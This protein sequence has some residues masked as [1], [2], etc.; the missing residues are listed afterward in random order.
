MLTHTHWYDNNSKAQ[1]LP[2]WGKTSFINNRVQWQLSTDLFVC[3]PFMH[4]IMPLRCQRTQEHPVFI[5][6]FLFCF[7][8]YY[9]SEFIFYVL[10]NVFSC[11]PFKLYFKVSFE[12][13]KE[14]CFLQ[15]S[16]LP[17]SEGFRLSYQHK[18]PLDTA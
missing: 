9:F 18:F 4:I 7:N 14:F 3:T 6:I 17:R 16:R 13:F 10:A 8:C 11:S 5:F 2:N 12:G 1:I 15:N